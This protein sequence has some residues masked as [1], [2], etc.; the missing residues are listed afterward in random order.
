MNN[1]TWQL[2]CAYADIE[3]LRCGGYDTIA[4]GDKVITKKI[5]NMPQEKGLFRR[6]QGSWDG[7]DLFFIRT[8]LKI[9][10]ERLKSIEKEKER[11]IVEAR[12]EEKSGDVQ[13]AIDKL[14]ALQL[15]D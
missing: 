6:I 7:E 2:R 3:R 8:W 4:I 13:D 10:A 15:D 12:I 9:E 5:P 11:A 1:R 14:S